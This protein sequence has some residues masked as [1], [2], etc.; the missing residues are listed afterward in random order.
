MRKLRAAV[1]QYYKR[2]LP[3]FA[4]CVILILIF[5]WLDRVVATFNLPFMTLFFFLFILATANTLDRIFLQMQMP[6]RTQQKAFFAFLPSVFLGAG[7]GVCIA[8]LLA[9]AAEHSKIR[10]PRTASEVFQTTL[11]GTEI[12][13]GSMARITFLSFLLCALSLLVAAVMARVLFVFWQS[14]VRKTLLLIGVPLLILSGLPLLIF[15]MY[16]DMVEYTFDTFIPEGIY[17]FFF[18]NAYA[19]PSLFSAKAVQLTVLLL[20]L[21]W[22]YHFTKTEQHKEKARH[23]AVLTAVRV[24]AV[25]AVTALGIVVVHYCTPVMVN[26][27]EADPAVYE[28]RRQEHALA[29]DSYWDRAETFLHQPNEKAYRLLQTQEKFAEEPYRIH[30]ARHITDKYYAPNL[31]L[32]YTDFESGRAYYEAYLNHA[33]AYNYTSEKLEY[34]GTVFSELRFFENDVP[35]IYCRWLYDNGCRKEAIAYYQ[36]IPKENPDHWIPE[37][38]VSDLPLYWD[39][40]STENNFLRYL[41]FHPDQQDAVFA[42]QE[43]VTIISTYT[44]RDDAHKGVAQFSALWDTAKSD[45]VRAYLAE[46]LIPYAE[47]TL[48]N[49]APYINDLS[50]VYEAREELKRLC[51]RAGITDRL[52]SGI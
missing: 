19:A 34:V 39:A 38:G 35:D 11:F 22:D 44:T 9:A 2:F 14:A 41:Y 45:P 46:A 47:E 26:H 25:C 51:E 7:A 21:R 3:P 48:R 10:A 18:G 4:V 12:F 28:K 17:T 8:R 29:Y 13:G 36:A 43:I 15:M 32:P 37:F 16:I 42:A 5:Q 52:P 33:A 49:T 24:A 27:Y 1:W 50:S 6:R 31:H 20:C 30:I 40:P 23:K